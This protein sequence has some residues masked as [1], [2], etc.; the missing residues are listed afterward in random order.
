MTP[1]KLLLAEIKKTYAKTYP[2]VLMA[3]TNK[4]DGLQA[5]INE[6][7]AKYA[8]AENRADNT[9]IELKS[10]NKIIDELVEALTEYGEHRGCC[11]A[12]PSAERQM[13]CT[14]GFIEALEKVR[15]K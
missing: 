1:D 3:L 2:N 5:K 6:L 15:V 9:A 10:K 14:C 11:M 12:R 8:C 13:Q 7:Q 4:I